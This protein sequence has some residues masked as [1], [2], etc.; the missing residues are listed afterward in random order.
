MMGLRGC[1]TGERHTEPRNP[2]NKG[3][4]RVIGEG[5]EEDEGAYNRTG[6]ID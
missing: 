4:E 1:V 2:E 3:P 5:R 6:E